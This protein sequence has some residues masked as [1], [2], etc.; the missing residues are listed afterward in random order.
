MLQGRD[1]NHPNGIGGENAAKE[2]TLGFTAEGLLVG[3]SNKG[4]SK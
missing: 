4:E 1:G 3:V 2:Q